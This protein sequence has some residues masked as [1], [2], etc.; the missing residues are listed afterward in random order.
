MYKGEMI[1]KN[2]GHRLDQHQLIAGV[3]WTNTICPTAVFTPIETAEPQ[4]DPTAGPRP[5]PESSTDDHE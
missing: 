5:A 3:F 1:R 4:D 2:C